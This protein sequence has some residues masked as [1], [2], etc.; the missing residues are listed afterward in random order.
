MANPHTGGPQ[1]FDEDDGGAPATHRLRTWQEIEEEA[2]EKEVRLEDL[3]A[4]H[5]CIGCG[6]H[7]DNLDTLEAHEAECY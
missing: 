2:I 6:A 5:F 3:T 4:A 1:I 7:F